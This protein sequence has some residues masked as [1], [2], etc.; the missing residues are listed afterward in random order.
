MKRIFILFFVFFS[1]LSSPAI[2][3]NEIKWNILPI[4][5]RTL[6]LSYEHILNN[7]TGL[8]ATGEYMFYPKEIMSYADI[9]I[10]YRMYFKNRDIA[11]TGFWGS[12]Y[13]K[14]SRFIYGKY[15]LLDLALKVVFAVLFNAK[16]DDYKT[17]YNGVNIGYS[18]GYKGRI[19]HSRIYYGG[20]FG[21]GV[22]VFNYVYR[23]NLETMEKSVIP[24]FESKLFPR[25]G[26]NFGYRF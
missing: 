20:Y 21:L 19:G 2:A 24:G 9:S 1:F 3:Q 23:L 10:E 17:V 25:G 22:N 8:N 15:N 12:P 5:F 6:C 16:L 14:Y 18:L 7:K 13:I 4:A 26:I 11:A